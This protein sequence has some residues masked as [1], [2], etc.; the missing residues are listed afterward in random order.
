MANCSALSATRATMTAVALSPCLD[1]DRCK[2]SNEVVDAA[3]DEEGECGS[4]T[5]AITDGA[6]AATCNDERA[7]SGTCSTWAEYTMGCGTCTATGAGI[8]IGIGTAAVANLASTTW[9]IW[10]ARRSAGAGE[11]NAEDAAED[12]DAA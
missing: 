6:A 12:E 4:R 8:G 5:A 9:C 3:T 7:M 1:F 2:A 11:A 10:A